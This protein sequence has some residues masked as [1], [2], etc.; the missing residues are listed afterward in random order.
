MRKHSVAQN[1]AHYLG[2]STLRA[3]MRFAAGRRE[4]A[5]QCLTITT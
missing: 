2:R 5:R 3:P 4:A 1:Y